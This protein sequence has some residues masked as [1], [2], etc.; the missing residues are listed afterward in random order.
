[1]S[2]KYDEYLEKHRQAVKKAYQ[3]IAAYIPELTDVEATRNIEFHDMSKNTPDEY[4]PYDNYFYGEQTPAI[5]E[6][7]NRAWLMH[8]HRNPHHW[9]Y[10]V[11]INDEPKEGTILIE[12]PYPYIIEMICDWWAFSW[13]KGDLSEM[14]AW[15]K[16]HA[17]YI[18]MHN[19]RNW[20][21]SV[22]VDEDITSPHKVWMTPFDVLRCT[23]EMLNAYRENYLETKDKQDWWQMIQLLPSSYNQRRT[24]ML[25]YEV[26]ANIYKSRRNHKLDEWH[27]FCDWIESL[28]YSELITGE[29]KG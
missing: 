13:I 26:L 15:Y 3:W 27:T 22:I 23:I 16:D 4:T 1:M 28:P 11:L 24:V 14:F 2:Q 7:F 5:I 19:H 9:Q 8:I 12:M 21:E 29:K 25:N 6:A 10:W 20:I 18:K 17:D